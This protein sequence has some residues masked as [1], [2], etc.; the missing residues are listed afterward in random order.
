MPDIIN[1]DGTPIVEGA[2]FP[3]P[4]GWPFPPPGLV[5]LEGL[6]V[7]GSDVHANGEAWFIDIGS[8][9]WRAYVARVNPKDPVSG[10]GSTSGAEVSVS[11]RP[12]TVDW[13]STLASD[14]AESGEG[15][16]VTEYTN[17]PSLGVVKVGEPTNQNAVAR[18]W[19]WP[20]RLASRALPAG[21]VAP[22]QA[23]LL[24]VLPF[25]LWGLLAWWLYRRMKR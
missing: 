18:F 19:S 7:Y 23:G 17:D 13:L 22:W 6:N 25:G 2:A 24:A 16:P 1:P 8:P 10:R 14:A 9:A 15:D 5:G 3:S 11:V 12:A 20:S 4:H 21:P